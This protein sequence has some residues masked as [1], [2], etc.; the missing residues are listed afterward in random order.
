M[1]EYRIIGA[2]R[3]SGAP[4]DCIVEANDATHAERI[5]NSRGVIIRAVGERAPSPEATAIPLP[6]DTSNEGTAHLDAW[7]PER[8]PRRRQRVRVVKVSLKCDADTVCT[9]AFGVVMGFFFLWLLGLLAAG[10]FWGS[11]FGLF[12]GGAGS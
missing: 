8:A 2:E 12:A 5:A 7:P 3:E 9:I 4:V 6:T 10:V 1:A 11:I